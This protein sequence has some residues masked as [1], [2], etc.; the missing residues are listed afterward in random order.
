MYKQLDLS[1]NPDESYHPT[2]GPNQC[3][4]ICNM[5]CLITC[6]GKKPA[7]LRPFPSTDDFGFFHKR[8]TGRNF[9]QLVRNL[10]EE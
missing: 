3:D 5:L 6:K 9:S 2:L 1:I 7:C 8:R 10:G 4:N